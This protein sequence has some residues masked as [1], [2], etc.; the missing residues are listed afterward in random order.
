MKWITLVLDPND[1][2]RAIVSGLVTDGR[3]TRVHLHDPCMHGADAWAAMQ[4]ASEVA[5]ELGYGI[6]AV[7]LRERFDAGACD[8]ADDGEGAVYSLD[9]A[10]DYIE[11]ERARAAV[12]LTPEGNSTPWGKGPRVLLCDIPAG[13]RFVAVDGQTYTKLY[14][15]STCT[16]VRRSDGTRT[17]FIDAAAVLPEDTGR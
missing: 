2:D 17:T 1:R 15:G 7:L 4:L 10:R 3:V 14:R 6:D 9:S 8:V 11:R 12:D 13:A 16:H 5:G